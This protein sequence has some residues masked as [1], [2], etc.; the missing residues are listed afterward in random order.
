MGDLVA[1]L[2][3][4]NNFRRVLDI[5]VY[6]FVRSFN[7]IAGL[8]IYSLDFSLPPAASNPSVHR[9]SG[10]NGFSFFVFDTLQYR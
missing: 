3:G 5:D 10:V 1:M 6:S 2:V 8:I 7:D 4:E 9:V